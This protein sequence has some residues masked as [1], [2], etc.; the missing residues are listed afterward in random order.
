MEKI[1]ISIV[2]P[3]FNSQDNLEELFQRIDKVLTETGKRFQIIFVD[4]ASKDNSWQ[5]LQS[6]KGIGQGKVT[7]IQ[8]KKNAGQHNAIICG[9]NLSQGN[10]TITMDDDLQHPPEEIPKLL[11]T[12][13]QTQSD[14]VY[15]MYRS[16]KHGAIRSAGSAAVQQ[17]TKYF[18]DYGK[19][20]GSSFRLFSKDLVNK[21]KGHSQA[22]VY[23]DEIIHWYTSNISQV[24]VEHNERKSGKSSYSFFKLTSMYL[25]VLINFTAWPL[26]LMTGFGLLFSLISFLVG[27]VFIYRR[28]N[29][30][31]EVPGF[32]ALIVAI[33]FSTS[34]MLFCFGIIGQYLYKIYQKQHGKPP[35]TIKEML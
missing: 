32:T 12:Y 17:S 28:L 25:G 11:K 33:A 30:D 18:A 22:F 35:Y 6:I 3:V 4:D 27:L 19:A 5:K 10:I 29:Y 2:I 24:E 14:V 23:L 20:S 7:A 26:R 31:I 1:D 34:L 21:L 9:L 8:L 15:G 16:K 13:E